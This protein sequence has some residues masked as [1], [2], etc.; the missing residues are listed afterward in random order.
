MRHTEILSII[1]VV[2]LAAGRIDGLDDGEVTCDKLKQ[3]RAK[4]IDDSKFPVVIKETWV[5]YSSPPPHLDSSPMFL[6]TCSGQATSNEIR[7][8]CSLSMI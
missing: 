7:T 5:V 2:A 8:V 1:L 6:L 4:S 3:W